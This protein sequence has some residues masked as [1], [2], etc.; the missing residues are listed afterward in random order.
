[1]QTGTGGGE[2]VV[3]SA[4]SM[5]MLRTV[6]L[7]HSDKPDF[8]NQG[9]GI[10]NYLGAAA[11]SPDGT[12]AWIPS[13]QDNIRRG[14][15]RNGIN[16]N[17]QNTV[18]A[19]SSRIDLTN[20]QEDYAARIDHDNSSVAS[21]VAYDKLGVYMFVALETSREIAVIAAHGHYELY[22]IQAGRAPQGLTVSTDG[23]KLYVSNF[24][25][26]SVGVYDLDPLLNH[27]VSDLPL[28]ATLNAVST[29]KLTAQVLQGKQLFYDAKDTRLAR[30]SYMSCAACHNDG[31]QDGR[32][33]DLTGMGE[34]LR[35]TIS[36]RGRAGA[37][38]FLH[39]S[40]NFDEVQDF[41]GQI[42][43]LAG[44]TGLMSDAVFQTGTRSQP[45]GDS[46][47]G[48]SASL[49]AL[50]AYVVS[51]NSFAPS[52]NRN[53]DGTLTTAAL[54]GQ[55]VFRLANCAACH[56]GASFT[57]SGANTLVNIGTM[58]P[59]SGQRL[60][61]PLSGIDVPTLRDAWATAPYLHDGSAATLEAAVR[62]HNG[63]SVSDADLSNLTSYVQQ[64]GSDEVSAPNGNGAG[65]TGRYYANMTLSG[66][67]VSTRL[68]NVNFNWANGG[69][70]A[71]VG[72]DGFSV[73]WTGFVQ[74]PTT[75]SYRFRTMSDDGVRLWINGVQRINDWT[76]HAARTGTTTSMTLTAG[77]KYAV[78]M[79]YYENTGQAVAQLSWRLPGTTSYVIVPANNLYGN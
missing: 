59:S 47:A 14:T 46:K 30:D 32:V 70:G 22:R 71:G 9:S 16:L 79:E 2:L 68:E 15:L 58:K 62:A 76:N 1:V 12:Q 17:F 13:K 34:G 36:L 64:I 11:I 73:R 74:V 39:W 20:Q 10:P 63:V 78:S 53:A 61:G 8:E 66:N 44:G 7:R 43:N 45:L 67:P 41:E 54:S 50:A 29:E 77:V 42:R 33:W 69:P 49:D 28:L 27:G 65:L 48:Q 52:P 37:Q 26:R 18:R 75:G 38:G 5:A 31:G 25:D 3:V 51:L 24:M 4:G 19:I 56:S 40:N 55:A 35:N 6:T 23:L 60:G 57:N 72:S 21:A